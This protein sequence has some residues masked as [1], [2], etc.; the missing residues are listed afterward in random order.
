MA[1]EKREIVFIQDCPGP[2]HASFIVG[3]VYSLTPESAFRWVRR[4]YAEYR[5]HFKGEIVGGKEVTKDR[6]FPES[7][8]ITPPQKAVMA[9]AKPRKKG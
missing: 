2:G 6:S 8:S 1:D 3:H 7:T 4:G 9:R 5:E